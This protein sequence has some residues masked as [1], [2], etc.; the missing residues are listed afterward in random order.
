MLGGYKDNYSFW[1]RRILRYK[2]F[3]PTNTAFYVKKK[4]NIILPYHPVHAKII[5]YSRTQLDIHPLMT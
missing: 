1:I 2:M 4:P 3:R 5:V